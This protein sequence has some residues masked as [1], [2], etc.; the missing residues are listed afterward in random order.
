MSAVL[1]DYLRVPRHDVEAH[2][3]AAFTYD[4]TDPY[5]KEAFRIETF[6]EELDHYCFPRGDLAKLNRIFGSDNI[7]DERSSAPLPM[8]LRFTATLRDEQKRL[9]R[10][11]MQAGYGTIQAPPRSGKTLLATAA[12]CRLKQRAMM[13]AHREDLCHQLEETIRKFTNVNELEEECGHKLV[14]VLQDWDDF[15]PLVTLSTYQCFVMSRSGRAVLNQ[16]RNAFG[17][18][19]VDE[20]HMVSRE[21]FSEVVSGTTAAY[22]LGL[23][24]TPTR[25]DGRHVVANDMI[26]PVVTIG[27]GEQL[28]VQYS[29]EYTGC[30]VPD[31][32]SWNVMWNR[33]VKRRRRTKTIARKVVE[34]V[35]DGHFCLVTTDRLQHL[36]D[37]QFAIQ[38]I[39]PDITVG[40][41]SS[42]TK[43]RDG[44]RLAA[45]RGEYQVVVAMNKIV[46]LGYNIP[47]W[48]CFHNT[49]PMANQQNWYQRISRIRTPME[50]A[51]KGDD[52]IKPTP[53]AR[54]WIDNGHPAIYAYKAL[55]KREN[56]RLGFQCLNETTERRKGR[57]KGFGLQPEEESS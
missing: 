6:H 12:I 43:D 17:L 51:F 4:L 36:D 48:S 20:V 27:G 30:D 8:R 26:G 56:A 25:K 11:W 16:H 21:L 52:W 31:F 40:L 54:V 46:E 13:L 41:L 57:G 37:L 44:F 29:W 15:F 39:D 53:V 10:E 42:K 1:S 28:P 7:R 22:R 55:V 38:S 18:V 24:A 49:L 9:V 2:H 47:R 33:L 23:T 5:T 14:G 19:I 50:P 3:I 35:Q 32:S 45:K 34:D